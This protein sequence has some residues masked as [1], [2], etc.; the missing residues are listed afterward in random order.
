MH[1]VGATEF[2]MVGGKDDNR[3]LRQLKIIKFIEN[4]LKMLVIIAN[5]VEI[6]IQ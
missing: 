1:L 6:I 5:S 4:R 2:P 3:I